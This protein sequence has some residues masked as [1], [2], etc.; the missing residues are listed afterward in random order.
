MIPSACAERVEIWCS[1]TGILQLDWAGYADDIVLYLLSLTSLQASLPLINSI[2]KQFKLTLN[3]KKTETMTLNLCRCRRVELFESALAIKNILVE[4][5][6]KYI[7]IIVVTII[8]VV[9]IIIIIKIE[10]H[11]MT[12]E[13]GP[14]YFSCY[15]GLVTRN[16]FRTYEQNHGIQVVVCLRSRTMVWF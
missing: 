4:L 14:K 11:N 1:I 5:E 9:I 6:L 15:K 7:I 8:I 3:S 12:S 2:F 16:D 10:F 13:S